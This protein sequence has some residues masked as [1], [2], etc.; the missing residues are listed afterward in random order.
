MLHVTILIE[1]E[2][3]I[4]VQSSDHHDF[5][6]ALKS[7]RMTVTTGWKIWTSSKSFSKLDEK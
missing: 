5:D 2:R 1:I 4:V 3:E 7:P 6:W